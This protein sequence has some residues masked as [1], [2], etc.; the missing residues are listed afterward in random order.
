MVDELDRLEANLVQL[1]ERHRAMCDEN[2]RLRQQAV[3]LEHANKLLRE[4]LAEARQ[5]TEN[6]YNTLPD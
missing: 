2:L 4:R 3:A 5:R 6:L 1:L